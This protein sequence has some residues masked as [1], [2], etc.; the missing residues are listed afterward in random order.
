MV[1]HNDTVDKLG[2][3][4]D[5]KL[6]AT[7]ALDGEII[8]WDYLLGQKKFNLDGP[9]SDI[10]FLEWHNKGNVIVAGST[11]NSIWLWNGNN[12]A[13][14]NVFQGHTAG[15][16]C[17]GFTPDGKQIISAAEDCTLRLWNPKTAECVFNIKGYGFHEGPINCMAF[18]SSGTLVATGSADKTVCISNITTGKSLARTAEHGDSVEGLVFPANFD[19]VGTCSI[20]GHV[21]LFD[22][23]KFSLK[24]KWDMG[25]G[26][27]RIDHYKDK[28]LFITSSIDGKVF[29]F[30]HRI[31][32]P[33]AM[34]HCH[35]SCIQ[36]FKILP[37]G[38]IISADDDGKI[39][40]YDMRTQ[41][42]VEMAN[43]TVQTQKQTNEASEGHVPVMITEKKVE[44][45]KEKEIESVDQ[46]NEDKSV[47]TNK[48]N[49]EKPNANEEVKESN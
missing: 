25:I 19:V 41:T 42:K 35:G 23:N 27:N 16:T 39:Y 21:R 31:S 37:S 48:S 44:E 28:N 13:F 1:G 11:D 29:L 7:A 22:V 45:P 2:F 18:S 17:G 24:E 5:G 20:D 14:L 10:S 43:S 26:L 49:D 8:V 36:D 46:P 30:D 3:N 9:T 34:V 12:G 6:L 4:F 38:E 33:V 15:V 47:V 40:V 32:D